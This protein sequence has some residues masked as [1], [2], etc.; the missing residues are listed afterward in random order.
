MLRDS[1]GGRVEL[2]PR[3]LVGSP[4]LRQLLESGVRHSHERGTLRSRDAVME[5][6]SQHG[7]GN[8]AEV[9]ILTRY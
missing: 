7:E 2:D 4:L 5:L 9:P 6:L 8:T 3:A 1:Y